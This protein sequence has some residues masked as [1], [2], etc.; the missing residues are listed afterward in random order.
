[1]H[2]KYQQQ[3]PHWISRARGTRVDS[4]WVIDVIHTSK[5]R[6]LTIG[7]ARNRDTSP[8][9]VH[10]LAGV[11]HTN[12]SITASPEFLISPEVSS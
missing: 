1:M 2:L 10:F 4:L 11:F 5:Q 12:F 9:Y 6:R 3:Q 7:A 8:G